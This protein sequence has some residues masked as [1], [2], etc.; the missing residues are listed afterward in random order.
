MRAMTLQRLSV[1]CCHITGVACC[2]GQWWWSMERWRCSCVSSLTWTDSTVIHTSCCSAAPLHCRSVSPMGATRECVCVCVHVHA[3]VC[4]QYQYHS[5]VHVCLCRRVI[6]PCQS[7]CEAAKEG[8]ESVLQM[9]NAS[10]PDFLR[11]SQFHNVTMAAPGATPTCYTPR[12]AKGRACEEHTYTEWTLFLNVVCM[13]SATIHYSH[14]LRL[15][16]FCLQLCVEALTA[17]SVQL[18]FVSHRNW[19]VMGIMTAMTGV[20]KPTVVHT[21]THTSLHFTSV[22]SWAYTL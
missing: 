4:M 9:F 20:M 15:C 2:L 12:N 10:W 14:L 3:H 18:E 7:F 16:V 19:C 22:P 6:L 8:C 5:S 17:S 1:T 13:G 21:H 11:C